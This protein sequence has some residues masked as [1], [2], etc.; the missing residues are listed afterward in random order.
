[1]IIPIITKRENNFEEFA[2]S[3]S[4]D[5]SRFKRLNKRERGAITMNSTRPDDTEDW[6][7]K[8]FL[9]DK[10][11]D[12]CDMTDPRNEFILDGEDDQSKD[13]RAH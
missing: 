5:Y 4:F 3:L 8:I 6:L 7:V 11:Y 12:P 10:P 9:S 13:D 2:Q 1:M